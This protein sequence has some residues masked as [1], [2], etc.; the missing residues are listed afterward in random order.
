V[1]LNDVWFLLFIFIIAGYLI[2]DGFDMG[3]GI[4]LL[5]LAQNDVERRTFLNSIGPV[6]DGNEVWL[7][8]GGGV[9]FAVFPLVYASLF[10]GLYL[11]FVLVLLVMI[12]RTVALEFRSKEEGSRWR[13]TWD[14]V[15]SIASIG[16]AFLLGLAFGNIVDGLPVDAD[17]NIET[18]LI[19]LLTPFALLVGLT[20]V[21]MFAVQGAIYLLIKT[22]GEIRDRLER[23]VPKLLATFFVLNTIVVAFLV[24]TRAEITDRYVDDIWPVVFPAGALAALV[25][26]W[27]YV[28]RGEDFRAFIASSVMI[29]L[30]LIS[31]GIGLYPNLI[32]STL[33]PAY[34]LTIFNAAS[35][36]N[37]LVICLIF[38]LIGMPFVLAYTTGVY[39]IFRG[40][41]VV[42]SHGY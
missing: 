1:T 41:T 19:A 32:V 15:F 31:G 17:G 23:A 42:D 37:T 39:Y 21:A 7:V 30:L 35:A 38:A 4:L 25:A 12:L 6:W 24:L 8:L 18:S 28:R 14:A 20:T 40:K 2:L 3:V 11:A 13:S 36:D 16:L 29:A 34:S 26:A 9:L 10:S 22:E 5:P 33:D 27:V